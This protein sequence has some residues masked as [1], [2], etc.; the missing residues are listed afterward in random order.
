MTLNR[1][2]FESYRSFV[3]SKLKSTEKTDLNALGIAL[4]VAGEA[5]EFVKA[6]RQ[7]DPMEAKLELGDFLFYVVA[8]SIVTDHPIEIVFKV[9]PNRNCVD[10][11]IKFL[12]EV[13]L[14]VDYIKKR[15]W[16]L[17]DAKHVDHLE[18]A[19]QYLYTILSRSGIT[20]TEA[21]QLNKEKLSKRYPN[22][23]RSNP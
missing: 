7:T 17:K 9:E 12:I 14:Y 15:H 3:E 10:P 8:L 11:G 1:G 20:L 16:N 23:F 21:I 13:G 4:G 5:A 22:G 18:K 6:C 19:F 2:E